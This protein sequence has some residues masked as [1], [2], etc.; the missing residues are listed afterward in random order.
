MHWFK[1][2]SA[3]VLRPQRPTDVAKISGQKLRLPPTV[4]RMNHERLPRH[5]LLSCYLVDDAEFQWKKIS[6][7]KEGVGVTPQKTT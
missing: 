7:A 2:V 5:G 4:V 6:S 1:H 3:L